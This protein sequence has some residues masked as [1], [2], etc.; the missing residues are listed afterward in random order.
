[1]ER[2]KDKLKPQF[3]YLNFYKENEYLFVVYECNKHGKQVQRWSNHVHKKH[4]CKECAKDSVASDNRLSLADIINRFKDKYGD[5]YD[6][7]QVDYVNYNTPVDI[8][9]SQH[10]VFKQRPAD[11]IRGK[12]G[13]PRCRMTCITTEDFIKLSNKVHGG[14][15]NYDKTTFK[16]KR[17]K[18]TITCPI[19][20]DF[21][22]DADVHLKGHKCKKCACT[23]IGLNNRKWDTQTFIAKS[24]AVFG[25]KYSYEKAACEKRTDM[26]TITCREH[27]DFEQLVS[28]HLLGK[29]GC[30]EC[31]DEVEASYYFERHSDSNL[32]LFKINT[33]NEEFLKVGISVDPVKRSSEIKS[34]I[35]SVCEVEIIT[36][37]E[38]YS[39]RVWLAE[40]RIHESDRFDKYTPIATFG[41]MTECYTL[42]NLDTFVEFFDKFGGSI[43]KGKD[44]TEFWSRFNRL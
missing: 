14:F 28:N 7:S 40:K 1:M 6:Y 12:Q 42:S 23:V 24:T 31:R 33:G 26:V 36:T 38:D 30:K 2:Y 21:K 43:G 25:D 41:G 13:C 27:G 18:V 20:G 32:Y 9:C 11:H 17:Y 22:T 39:R 34:D 5:T 44:N 10:G 16:G 35:G 19:H 15:Y 3:K 4:G 29:V 8:I 37:V